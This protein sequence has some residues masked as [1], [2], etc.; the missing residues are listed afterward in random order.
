MR[1]RGGALTFVDGRCKGS[2][3][4]GELRTASRR[5]TCTPH[6]RRMHNAYAWS[7]ARSASVAGTAGEEDSGNRAG[8]IGLPEKIPVLGSLGSVN[9]AVSGE[10][11]ADLSPPVSRPLAAGR[12][13]GH[14]VRA[15]RAL[16]LFG[17]A[18]VGAKRLLSRFQGRMK[19]WV[20]PRRVREQSTLGT[21]LGVGG[22]PLALR[23]RPFRALDTDPHRSEPMRPLTAA[24]GQRKEQR[25][26]CFSARQ[27][28]SGGPGMRGSYELDSRLCHEMSPQCCQLL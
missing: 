28:Q 9:T 10:G 4:L 24:D 25:S 11:V 12:L 18:P 16:F 8:R 27:R 15:V 22:A 5:E 17:F 21:R 20:A 6:A 1:W 7:G 2:N 13:C 19:A 26:P 14:F 3:P 23:L